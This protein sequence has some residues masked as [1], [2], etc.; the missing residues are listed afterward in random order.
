MQDPTIKDDRE[1]ILYSYRVI[2]FY[3]LFSFPFVDSSFLG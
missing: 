2:K 1:A 3:I